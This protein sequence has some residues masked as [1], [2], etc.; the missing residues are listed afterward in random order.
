MAKKYFKKCSKFLVIRKTQIKTLKIPILTLVRIV[1][2]LFI[3]SRSANL[4]NPFGNEFGHFSKN[5]K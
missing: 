3:A 5:W 4:Y 1:E 2:H